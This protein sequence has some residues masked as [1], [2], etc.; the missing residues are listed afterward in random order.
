MDVTT[1]LGLPPLTKETFSTW[2]MAVK[3]VAYS[4]DAYEHL[5]S[6]PTAL[7]GQ[8]VHY[9]R[10]KNTIRAMTLNSIQAD[11]ST[12]LSGLKDPTPFEILS[13]LETHFDTN[14]STHHRALL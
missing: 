10:T 5:S 1:Q 8:E 14:S 2:E 12:Y 9:N 7:S 13:A 11:I 4:M 6:N 3:S